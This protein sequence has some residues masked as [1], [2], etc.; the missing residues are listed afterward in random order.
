MVTRDRC[1]LVHVVGDLHDSLLGE[2]QV[3]VLV[4]ELQRDGDG[5]R[6]AEQEQRWIQ[7]GILAFLPVQIPGPATLTSVWSATMKS[8]MYFM[9]L[10]A[11]LFTCKTD[12]KAWRSEEAQSASHIPMC[13]QEGWPRGETEARGGT[14]SLHCHIISHTACQSP[15]PRVLGLPFEVSCLNSNH[16]SCPPKTPSKDADSP[17]RSP[18]AHHKQRPRAGCTRRSTSWKSR[19]MSSIV[20]PKSLPWAQVPPGMCRCSALWMRWWFGSG[21]PTGCR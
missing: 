14:D 4:P 13:A 11:S 3:E 18:P 17:A 8:S 1:Y 15:S 9:V 12:S 10:Q 20:F 5:E 2:A 19:V 16:T 21:V 6:S 7:R